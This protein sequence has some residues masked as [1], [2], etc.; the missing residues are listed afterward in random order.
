MSSVLA[1]P[2]P[3]YILQQIES[4]LRSRKTCFVIQKR[5]WNISRLRKLHCGYY[6]SGLDT[7]K[8]CTT[9]SKPPGDQFR[10]RSSS[11]GYKRLAR[12]RIPHAV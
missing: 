1:S 12:T 7:T 10:F 9:R 6:I 8:A 5:V 4:R 2:F 11:V 3:S